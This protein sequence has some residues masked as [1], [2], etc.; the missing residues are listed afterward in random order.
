M[1]V[2]H[3]APEAAV[4]GTIALIEEGDSVTIDARRLL[5]QLNVSDDVLGAAAR[6]LAAAET[7]LHARSDGQVRSAR[8]DGEQGRP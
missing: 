7:A 6:Q 4:G 2:G 3:I 5:V 1:V 8:I